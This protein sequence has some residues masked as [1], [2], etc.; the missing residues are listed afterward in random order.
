MAKRTLPKKIKKGGIA[1]IYARYSSHNQRDVS[2]EQQVEACMKYAKDSGLNVVDTYADRAI[3][4]RSDRRPNFQRMM[5]DAEA[6]KFEFVISWKSN[7][8]GR[9]M[10]QAM[11]NETRLADC[12]V[13]AVFVE[14]DF[15]DNAAGRFALRSMMNVNQFYSENMAEDIQRGL[16]DN[17]SKCL[18][19]GN[20]GFGFKRGEDGRY[21][22]DSPKDA[23]VRE[24]FE[25][26]AKRE[27]IVDIMNSLN[28]RGIKTSRGGKWNRSSFQKMLINERYRGVYIYRD[29]YIEGG[30]PRIVSDD[31][32]YKVQE[33]VNMNKQVKT[34]RR[35]TENGT[36]L[37][38]GKLFCGHCK[39]HMTGISGTSGRGYLHFYYT[40]RKRRVEKACKKRN[41]QRDYIERIVAKAIKDY[42]LN[43][44]ILEVIADQT[45]EYNKKQ[46]QNNELILLEQE[47]ASVNTGLQNLLRAIE[48]GI[49]SDTTRQRMLDLEKQ[50]ASLECK[51]EEFKFNV[52]PIDREDLIAG[53]AMFR[54]GDIEDK[55]FQAALFDT[56]LV[57]VYI[58]DNNLKLVFTFTGANNS[59]EVPLEEVEDA[60][61]DVILEIKDGV[62]V[63]SSSANVHQ[64][65]QHGLP[66]NRKSFL[67]C[68]FLENKL[69]FLLKP[70]V[71]LNIRVYN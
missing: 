46:L 11:L 63:R 1:V 2:I 22:L 36:Y 6:G 30:V 27:P 52:V 61:S 41:V 15:E 60:E 17:A 57:A 21:A 16:D 34:K 13:R 4:G 69:Y 24:I 38:T 68:S 14:E 18:V 31:I 23:I 51:I 28:E 65:L 40:C 71:S 47:L 32:F 26:V 20:G 53:L 3:T 66:S 19:N 42:C 44:E 9:N 56:F 54:D 43:D 7:R 12:G 62:L 55:R 58:Y 5:R 10:L 33:V 45:V 50:K 67:F 29:H 37:L 49:F 59:I 8:I 70:F 48:A 39:S 25:R 35:R 64:I